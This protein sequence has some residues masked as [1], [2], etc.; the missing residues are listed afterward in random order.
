MDNSTKDQQDAIQRAID[1]IKARANGQADASNSPEVVEPMQPP[2]NPMP[3]SPKSTNNDQNALNDEQTMQ[4]NPGAL[5]DTLK[6]KKQQ[7]MVDSLFKN[8]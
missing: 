1:A 3:Y 6:R 7:E 8:Q 5:L 4:V 2:A